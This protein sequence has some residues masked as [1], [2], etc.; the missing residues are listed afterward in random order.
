MLEKIKN[1]F[2]K[3]FGFISNLKN[4]LFKSK[5]KSNSELTL[6]TT[7]SKGLTGLINFKGKDKKNGNGDKIGEGADIIEMKEGGDQN[8]S[9][10]KKSDKSAKD[11][12]DKK[13]GDE[14][15]FVK[16]KKKSNS[17]SRV[18]IV[19]ASLGITYLGYDALYNEVP[20]IAEP[21]KKKAN[22][23]D[24]KKL[25]KLRK[26][27]PLGSSIKEETGDKKDGSE[28][29]EKSTESLE[30]APA[31]VKTELVTEKE[32]K[33]ENLESDEKT[34]GGEALERTP[35][36]ETVPNDE[37]LD[38]LDAEIKNLDDSKL[39]VDNKELENPEKVDEV[40][41]VEGKGQE[42]V[43]EKT[44]TD[45]LDLVEQPIEEEIVAEDVQNDAKEVNV[46]K[47]DKNPI[48]DG[49]KLQSTK[50]ATE[51]DILGE[52]SE[53]RAKRGAAP[54]DKNKEGLDINPKVE[55]IQKVVTSIDGDNEESKDKM[56]LSHPPDYD[57]I[58]RGLVYNCSGKHWA[59]LDRE[60][61]FQCKNNQ[62]WSKQKGGPPS[63]AIY[64][65]YL[66]NEDC[67][68]AQLQ[69]VNL[70]FDKSICQN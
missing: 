26:T 48:K 53:V 67:A 46:Q 6:V 17:R 8:K 5:E 52:M 35:S 56:N 23:I 20:V 25:D 19:F 13:E 55:N 49:K 37:N 2:S 36:T 68:R 54:S 9:S 16:V 69:K 41:N 42:L 12:R 11:E 34:E 63:C 59:C 30:G 64:E 45:E 31:E 51:L 58:G 4:K 15:D 70:K 10:D 40:E 1:I 57:R 33:L 62:I 38:E 24:K 32:E 50:T 21:P 22:K 47:K 29:T 3:V 7:L 18:I 65:V 43:T 39:N 44:E 60:E 14:P 28:G 61:F 66:T 27:P